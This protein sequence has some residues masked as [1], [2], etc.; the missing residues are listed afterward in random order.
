[1]VHLIASIAVIL[2]GLALA[3]VLDGGDDIRL[4]G[5]LLVAIGVLGLISRWV[6]SMQGDA[7]R[8]PPSRH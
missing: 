6:I 8:R 2:T 3:L 5:W 7:H 4:F 1:M